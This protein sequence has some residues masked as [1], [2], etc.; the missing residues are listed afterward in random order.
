MYKRQMLESL[1]IA[2]GITVTGVVFTVFFAVIT[3]FF[4]L[5]T[6]LFLAWCA[7]YGPDAVMHSLDKINKGDG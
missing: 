3:V 5:A 1:T 2:V 7:L 6:P 4:V